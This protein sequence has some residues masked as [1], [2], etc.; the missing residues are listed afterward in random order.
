M[1]DPDLSQATSTA[2]LCGT[3]SNSLP[4]LPTDGWEDIK[5]AS[6]LGLRFNNAQI[7]TYFVTRTAD[8]LPVEDFKS[9]NDS[10]FN[11]YICGHV[12]EIQVCHD[13]N[14]NLCVC[15]K[16]LPEMTKIACI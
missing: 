6:N 5:Q 16:C 11:L 3:T 10:A 4:A 8:G 7:I 9:I 13:A 15:A 1:I 2:S 14:S 12:Q